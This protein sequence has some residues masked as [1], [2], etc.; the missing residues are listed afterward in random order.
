[1]AFLELKIKVNPTFSEILIAELSVIGFDSFQEMED[2]LMA[3][4][5]E[6]VYDEVALEQIKAQY[7]N[8][9]TFDIEMGQLE[10]KNWNKIW[11]DNFECVELDT[12]CLVRTQTFVPDKKYEY[13][14]VIN[15]AMTF[16]TGHHATT[17]LMMAEVFKLKNE[18]QRLLD[19]GCGSGI[20]AILAKML[21]A[22]DVSAIDLEEGCVLNTLENSKL[23]S[24][25]IYSEQAIIQEFK[26]DK[27]YDSILANINKNVLLADLPYYSRLLKSGGTLVLSG[28]HADDIAD[29]QQKS[30]SENFTF[31]YSTEQGEW[32][33]MNL[34]KK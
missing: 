7:L 24:V 22:V 13:E 32:V 19:V 12:R 5:D 1:M 20:L 28:F 6:S 18:G 27:T 25:S 14:I 15:P 34:T 16:G 17:Q 29:L 8:L 11:E 2:Y 30:A 10:D 31:N 23:N 33:S 3:Y 21:G 26:T 9:F 4:V